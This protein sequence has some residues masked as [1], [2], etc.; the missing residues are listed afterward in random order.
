MPAENR[1]VR[2]S[3]QNSERE[4]IVADVVIVG[5]GG[6]GLAAA[7]AAHEAGLVPLVL[8]KDRLFGGS[9]A[10]SGGVI[11]LPNN[12]LQHAAGVQDSREQAIRYLDALVKHRGPGTSAE[13]RE[14]YVDTS[15]EV[16]EL[17]RRNGIQLERCE[18]WPDY[19]DDLPGGCPRGRSMAADYFDTRELG[20]WSDRLRGGPLPLPIK[21]TELRNLP[22]AK[23]TWFA[24][25]VGLRLAARMAKAKF[26][27]A[28]MVGMGAALQGRIMKALR[29]RGVRV[30]LEAPVMGFIENGGRIEGVEACIRDRPVRV[31][32]RQAVLIAA[33]GFARNLELRQKFLRHPTS[34]W[35]NANPGDSGEV[36]ELAIAAGAA[37]D[38]LD[39]QVFVAGSLPPGK[40]RPALHPPSDLGKPH[41]ILVDDK[42][43]RFCD[44]GG[45]YVATGEAMYAAGAVPCWA[46]F[47]SRARNRYFWAGA[48]PGHIPPAWLEQNYLRTAPSLAE[49]ARLCGIDPAA[50]Q[51]TVARFSANANK[52]IDPD[53]KRGQRAYDRWFGDPTCKPNPSL[54]PITQPPFYAVRI[55]PGDVGTFGGVVTDADGRVLRPDGSAIEGLYATGNTTASVFGRAYA[56]AGASIGASMVFGVRAARR[57]AR[58]ALRDAAV[59]SANAA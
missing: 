11:W 52:G 15:P 28:K 17:L 21:G 4:E 3:P 1:T 47:E 13:R 32:A 26:T 14:A 31:R 59:P 2:T 23:R 18:G 35:S 39:A 46:I 10:M 16:Y 7:L 37:T 24:K 53:F 38:A 58:E 12:P 44:E 57:I 42:G 41:I 48:R 5:S 19:H 25:L 54:G 22:L 51:A 43:Q 36:L 56:G 45:S 55:F 8:E 50:L 9:T 49:L 33:G 40:D 30:E 20:E 34:D 27:G 6:G 29:D